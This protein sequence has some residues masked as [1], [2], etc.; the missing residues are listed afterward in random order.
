MIAVKAEWKR[1]VFS[2][3]GLIYEQGWM[4]ENKKRMIHDDNKENLGAKLFFE[5]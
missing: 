5:W 1:E 4:T 3:A 2:L